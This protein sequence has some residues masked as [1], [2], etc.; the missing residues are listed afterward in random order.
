[1]VDD[2]VRREPVSL[3][4]FPDHQGKYREFPREDSPGGTI[5]TKKHIFDG[6]L[7]SDSLLKLNREF[8]FLNRESTRVIRERIVLISDCQS[9]SC[10][11]PV[12]GSVPSNPA[13]LFAARLRLWNVASAG[14]GGDGGIL[15]TMASDSA[16]LVEP[17]VARE[18]EST[19]TRPAAADAIPTLR[20]EELPAV[21]TFPNA[22]PVESYEVAIKLL[23]VGPQWAVV[24]PHRPVGLELQ[25]AKRNWVGQF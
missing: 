10:K 24:N 14:F 21:S 7:A 5:V 13:D 17:V 15:P 19:S 8:D 4:K 16:F 1:M 20:P 11:A 23:K 25:P 22:C 18:P 2:A 6:H 12:V 9:A 3:V